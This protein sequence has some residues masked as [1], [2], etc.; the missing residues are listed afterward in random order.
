MDAPSSRVN[1]RE[2]APE[3]FPLILDNPSDTKGTPDRQCRG[4]RRDRF[5]VRAF[6]WFRDNRFF[7][8]LRRGWSAGRNLHFRRHCERLQ[9]DPS[10]PLK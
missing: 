9:A 3:P 10:Q 8:E 6:D 5:L 4:E 2:S 7:R 1:R